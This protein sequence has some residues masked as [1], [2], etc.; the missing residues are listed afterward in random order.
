MKKDLWYNGNELLSKQRLFNFVIGVRGGGKT[1]Y[2]KKR[3]IE[4]FLKYG[5]QFIYLR[6]YQTE[7]TEMSN[8]ASALQRQGYFKDHKFECSK[9]YIKIDGV[10][11]GYIGT[12]S[13]IQ[14]LKSNEYPLVR[15]II[16]DEFLIDKGHLRYLDNEGGMLFDLAETIF[17]DRDKGCSIVC[18]GNSISVV[19]PMFTYFKI[20][21]IIYERF[22]L[23]KTNTIN[24]SVCI[25][26]YTNTEYSDMKLNTRLG[27]MARHS[28]WGAYAY[29]NKFLRDNNSFIKK[30][31]GGLVY[32]C[33]IIYEGEKYGIWNDFKDGSFY[34]D[35]IIEPKCEIVI[36]VDVNDLNAQYKLFNWK[37]F[38]NY[39]EFVAFSM[40]EGK[41]YFD[42]IETKTKLY[43][44]FKLV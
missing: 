12:L 4:R 39:V 30:R 33:T 16:F 5:E 1:F 26:M 15:S 38:K 13:R 18:I 20:K 23:G 28:D 24:E 8:W 35:K 10:I 3:C 14:H 17:R 43:E 2:W 27:R 7:L 42:S 21:P 32:S 36:A 41:C 11:A 9:K 34:C 31:E 37:G 40:Q 29:E 22:T 6:R 19:N 44:V 25:E